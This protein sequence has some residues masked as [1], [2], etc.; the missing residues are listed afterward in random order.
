MNW[1]IFAK[2]A[3][4]IATSILPVISPALEP[5]ASI[6]GHAIADA[7]VKTNPDGTPFDGPQKLAHVQKVVKDV[8]SAI[9]GVDPTAVDETL[10]EG[11]DA[12]VAATKVIVKTTG[13]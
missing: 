10:Q 6:I 5:L 11:I 7:Q 2:V 4:G 3:V 12:V 1:K 8:A 13:S 9:P